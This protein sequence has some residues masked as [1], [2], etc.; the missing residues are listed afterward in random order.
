MDDGVERQPAK[1]PGGGVAQTIGRPGMR[2]LVNGQRQHEDDELNEVSEVIE[3]PQQ[4]V[5]VPQ[6]N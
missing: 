2:R 1:P 3:S 4:N 5:S 6:D